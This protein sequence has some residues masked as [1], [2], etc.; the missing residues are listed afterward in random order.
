[1]SFPGPM[2]AGVDQLLI[3]GDQLIAPFIGNP[4]DI[5]MYINPYCK[6]DDNPYHRKTMGVDRPKKHMFW[7]IYS[8]I[9]FDSNSFSTDTNWFK[10]STSHP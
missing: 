3:L 9:F 1:M 10:G 7:S 2:C 4:D 8:S 5:L 6:V